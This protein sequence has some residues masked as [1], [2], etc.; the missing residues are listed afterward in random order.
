M[1][2]K[3][4]KDK[5]FEIINE[6]RHKRN[7]LRDKLG[8]MKREVQVLE[9]SLHQMGLDINQLALMFVDKD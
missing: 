1:I 4:E 6:I 5:A 9:D 3:E 2:T 8:Y 7:V